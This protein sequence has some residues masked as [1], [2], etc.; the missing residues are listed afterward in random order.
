[1]NTRGDNP[2]N[3]GL[4]ITPH[5]LARG[6]ILGVEDETNWIRDLYKL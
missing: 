5:G 4:S 2:M 3:A 1:M 6:E